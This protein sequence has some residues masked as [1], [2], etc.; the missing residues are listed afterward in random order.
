MGALCTKTKEVDDRQSSDTNEEQVGDTDLFSLADLVQQQGQL[1]VPLPSQ[2]PDAPIFTPEE[3]NKITRELRDVQVAPSELRPS[4]ANPLTLD[5]SRKSDF[6]D[7]GEAR[8]SEVARSR[9]FRKHGVKLHDA[10]NVSSSSGDLGLSKKENTV[11]D[12]PG[13]KFYDNH[14]NKRQKPKTE[15]VNDRS[16]GKSRCSQT[17]S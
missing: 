12:F 6:S 7:G 17:T 15:T 13:E 9:F 11:S 8:K 2:V 4:H 1:S 14:M 16:S 3:L 10:L 5:C